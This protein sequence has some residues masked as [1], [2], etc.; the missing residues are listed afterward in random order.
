M[1][2]PAGDPSSPTASGD[3][4]TI[5]ED[6]KVN[7]LQAFEPNAFLLNDTVTIIHA[8]TMEVAFCF[9][10]YVGLEFMAPMALVIKQRASNISLNPLSSKL[11]LRFYHVR[12]TLILTS[13]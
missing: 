13:V 3:I 9:A 7:E 4:P 8:K 11:L 2:T 12:A 1:R 5:A 10:C 6:K